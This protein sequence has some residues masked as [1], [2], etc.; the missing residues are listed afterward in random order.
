MRQ[1][2]YI[3]FT[4]DQ[5]RRA[6]EIDLE[7]FLLRQG[8]KLLS[9]GPEK[10][11]ASDHSITVRGNRWYDHA[12]EQGGGPISFLQKF[13]G[14]T[15]PEAVTRL[16]D[17]EQGK[18]FEPVDRNTRREKK[19]FSLPSASSNMRRMYAYLLKQRGISREVLDAF[20]HAKLIYESAEP[21]ADGSRE[22]HNAVFVGYDERG[23]AR[24]AHKRGLYALGEGFKRNVA[25][26][27]SRYSFHCCGTSDRVYAFEAPI[28]ML[29]FI[30]LH[31]QDWRRHS[32][33]ALCGVSDRALHWMLE[34]NPALQRVTLCLD[35]DKAGI[36]ASQRIMESLQ[37][38]GYTQVEAIFPSQKDWNKELT[39]GP[40][41]TKQEMTMNM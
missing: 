30:T 21:S 11:L 24:H 36:E 15:Y 28:D 23:A 17:G 12:A 32:Y 31:P 38:K 26:C 33:V 19:A 29:S 13:Y 5:K 1:I 25:G 2:P 27:D 8:E 9:S 18:A 4:D 22:H 35:N 41:P 39:D 3:H 14:M 6:G 20:V 34:Q 16:L 7:Q 37:G 10:R 40:V